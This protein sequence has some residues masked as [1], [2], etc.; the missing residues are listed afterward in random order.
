[1]PRQGDEKKDR[2]WRELQVTGSLSQ[3][4][5]KCYLRY[6]TGLIT[7]EDQT[8]KIVNLSI[9]GPNFKIIH[10]L[11]SCRILEERKM[12]T[13]PTFVNTTHVHIKQTRGAS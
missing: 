5:I 9:R 12:N 4:E 11:R 6:N 10:E 2:V 7:F 3:H 1:M 8:S 13:V